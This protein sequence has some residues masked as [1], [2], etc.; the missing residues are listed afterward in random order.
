MPGYADFDWVTNENAL[1]NTVKV[2]EAYWLYAN[3]TFF[4]SDIHWTASIGR[5][6][7]TD[8]LGINFR[9]DQERKS[10]L[11]HTV[12][13]EFDGASFK[14]NLDKVTPL[15]GSW[16]KLCLGRGLTNA[17][18]RFDMF[19][20]DYIEDTTKNPDIDMYG[21]IYVPYD[22]GQ[23]SIHTNYARAVNLIGFSQ[24][25]MNTFGLVM[26]GYD[27]TSIDQ[28]TGMPT[29]Q[30]DGSAPNQDGSLSVETQA[31]LPSAMMAYAPKFKDFGDL[32]L[33]TIMFKAEGIGDEI[34][35]F[36]DNTTLFVSWAGSKTHPNKGMRML[37]DTESHTGTS[38]WIGAQMPALITEEGRFGIE[39]NK[40][41]KYWRSVTYA[42]DTMIGSKIAARG[43]AIEA[44]YIQPLTKA[45]SF[46]LRYTK[47]NYDY[48]GS[49]AFFGEDGTPVSIAEY[50]A[51]ADTMGI[52]HAV[53]EA[54][55]IRAYIR[56]RY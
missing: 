49:N 39:W 30:L 27:P 12:N 44:Y 29:R 32:D 50:N 25:D 9:E 15:E 17:K 38:V 35:D 54:T 45:L 43:T 10:A 51:Y 55:D 6:P 13:V 56:Y 2:K 46:S 16:L 21:F 53:E 52:S 31:L 34:N 23:Y 14:F 7:S 26:K 18:P 5:R 20:A 8:G 22:N 4:G 1:D 19:G 11:A 41:S 42:E 37:G 48:T 33:A 40:G 47:I 28:T 24:N 36:L 3:D